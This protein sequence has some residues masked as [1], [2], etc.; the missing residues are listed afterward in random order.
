M[1]E[2]TV[3]IAVLNPGG[4]DPDQDFPD[5]AGQPNPAI[6]APVNYHGYAA[7]TGGSF[8]R[9]VAAVRER[10]F[11]NVLLLLRSDLKDSLNALRH[12]KQAG[13]TVLI[14]FKESGLHQV[15]Q[16]LQ[17]SGN[18]EC[19]AL[20]CREADGALSSTD[21]LLAVYQSAGAKIAEFI[22]T[23]YPIGEPNWNFSIPPAERRGIFMGTR[24]FDVPSRNHTL[25]LSAALATG[26]P[27]TV[28]NDAGRAGRKAV[29]ALATA[30]SDGN[31]TIID[32]RRPYP[33]YLQNM[34]RHRL[35]WQWDLSAVPGQV[36]GDSLLCGLPCVGGNGATERLAFPELC[37]H[38]RTLA[39][40]IALIHRLMSDDLFYASQT[41]SAATLGKDRLGFPLVRERLAALFRTASAS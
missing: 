35:V 37:G 7:A 31:L 32:G 4:R 40:G 19:L 20:L 18:T 25:A 5:F 21:D 38:G 41:A 8:L 15:S 34:T 12:L 14:S 1:S 30:Q 39:D 3:P 16:T 17:K 28:V 6:H 23:P 11:P 2:L 36:A 24:E 33:E 13:C 26:Y 29:E 22:P 10:R 27:I 9:S